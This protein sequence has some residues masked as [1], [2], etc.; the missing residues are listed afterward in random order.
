VEGYL[1]ATGSVISLERSGKV[2]L[3][4]EKVFFAVLLFAFFYFLLI[5]I[6]LVYSSTTLPHLKY[7]IIAK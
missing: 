7:K 2:F 1:S 6:F 3:E 5:A 4:R